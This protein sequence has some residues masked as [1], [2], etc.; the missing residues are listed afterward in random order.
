MTAQRLRRGDTIGIIAP[1]QV[2]DR[3]VYEE[4]I[5]CLERQGYRVKRGRNLYKATYGYLA[6]ETERAADL[7][8]M[9]ADDEVKLIL[10]G[11]G[12]GAAELLPLVDFEAIKAHPKLFLSYSDGTSLL[13]AIY[14]NTGLV[15]YYGQTPGVAARPS[16]YDRAQFEQHIIKGEAGPFVSNGE[17]CALHGGVGEGI[18]LG[19]YAGNMALLA[20]SRY[21]RT[22]PA[23]RYLLFLEDHETFHNVAHVSMLLSHLEQ[24]DFARQISGLLFGHYSTAAQPELRERLARFGQKHKV[25]VICCDDF[26][27]GENHAIPPIG[28]RAVMDGDQNTL[29]FC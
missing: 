27:H 15:T 18:L 28:R 19:G 10:F 23:A 17:R 3:A 11:G 26:G 1:S 22:D 13:A 8:A 6:A 7:N 2:P 29:W 14:L 21:F 16:A 5:R 12:E 4:N 9:A 20:G 25:P 24:S